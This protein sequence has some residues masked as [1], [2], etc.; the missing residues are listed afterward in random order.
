MTVQTHSGFCLKINR[1]STKTIETGRTCVTRVRDDK[2]NL[3]I[4]SETVNKRQILVIYTQL[5]MISVIMYFIV[6]KYIR[7]KN[8]VHESLRAGSNARGNV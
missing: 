5:V 7:T 3:S 1:G 4:C 2:C 8:C 6:R